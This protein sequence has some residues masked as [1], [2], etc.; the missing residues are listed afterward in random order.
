MNFVYLSPHF[1]PNY[2]RF[3]VHLNE[4][5]VNVF[6]VADE[7]YDRLRPELRDSLREYYR[8]ND[9]HH[10]DELLR[11]CGY[12]T[13]R[14]GKL[15]CLDSHNE[16]WLET[17][18]RLRTDFN[19]DGPK[20]DDIVLMKYKSQMK[21]IFREAGVAVA[22]GSLFHTLKDARDLIAQVG[23]P[24]IAKPDRGV[25][26]M[27]TFKIHNDAELLAFFDQKPPLDYLIEE[28]IQGEIFTFD[29]LTDKNGRPVFY[30]SHTYSQG[31]ME[32]VLDDSLIYYYSL[33]AI[34][35]DLEAAG[36]QVLKVYKIKARFFHFEFF[37]SVESGEIIALEVNIRPPG[38]LTTDM[39]NFAN[40]INIYK[41]WA[42]VIV[43][44]RFTAQYSRPYHCCYIARKFNKRY[45]HSHEEIMAEFG[46][47][48]VY[49]E[50]ISG[51]FSAALGNYG[52][53][54]RSPEPDQILS[55]AA[56][57]QKLDL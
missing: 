55:I 18:A 10:Y 53:L 14:H 3:C 7:S 45:A 39:F 22:R 37:R 5:G 44:N 50:E 16:Y 20:S 23:Y 48:I 12:F 28:F 49:Q 17:E 30:T 33:R 27:H 57:I 26:A 6:G 15:D 56:F 1:P 47:D 35:P 51:V 54:A 38:G 8:V 13:H 43:N 19:M 32:T 36:L 11:A 9:M 42:N 25:G 41:E 40:D 21:K 2:Y 4:L 46:P 29:G 52:Y 24:I 34:P 31:I